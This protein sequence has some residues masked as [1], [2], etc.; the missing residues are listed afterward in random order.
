MRA[1][2]T[3]LAERLRGTRVLFL[4]L[5]DTA[6][7]EQIGPCASLRF[8]PHL[9][10][11]AD[12]AGYFQA[13]DVYL[14]AAAADTFPRAVLEAL[15]CGTPVVGTNVGGI[16]EQ[17]RSLETDKPTGILVA[18]G[19]PESMA[20]AIEKLL[21]DE[22]LRQTLAANAVADARE[23]FD[24]VHQAHSQLQWYSELIRDQNH[25]LN[26]DSRHERSIC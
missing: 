3:L 10:N 5:G 24:V 17:L 22:P 8:V 15:A 13:A 23:R 11:L 21:T 4:A 9:K 26:E 2:V 20:L 19:D 1:A 6:P 16:P 12:V 14:H 7:P 25:I 18:P